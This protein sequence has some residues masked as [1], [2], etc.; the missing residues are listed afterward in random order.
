MALINCSECG[1]EISDKA[2]TCPHSGAPIQNEVKP[3]ESLEPK[4]TYE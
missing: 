4:G 1:K 3:E 2:N